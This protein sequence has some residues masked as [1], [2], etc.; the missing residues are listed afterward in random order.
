MPGV[1]CNGAAADNST[2]VPDIRLWWT[3]SY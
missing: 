2:F 1:V 3:D